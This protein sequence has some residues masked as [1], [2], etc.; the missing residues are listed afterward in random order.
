MTVNESKPAKRKK[1][2]GS[3]GPKNIQITEQMI[4]EIEILSGQ[5]FT[6]ENLQDYYGISSTTWY[7]KIKKH[8]EI[9]K[10]YRKGKTK[11][12]AF[13]SSKLMEAIRGGN[14]AATIFYLRTQGRWKVATD[15]D[16]NLKVLDVTPTSAQELKI[17]VTDPIEAAKIYQ[18]I[19]TE[20]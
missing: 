4:K 3:T 7:G 15:I 20:G 16:A 2:N 6:Q 8:P 18:K 1:T 5:G 14:I 11:A 17:T 19:M 12:L 9:E 10:A 13:V